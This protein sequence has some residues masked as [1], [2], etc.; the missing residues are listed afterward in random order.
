MKAKRRKRNKTNVT[1]EKDMTSTN[2]TTGGYKFA[3]HVASQLRRANQYEPRL[4]WAILSMVVLG[5]FGHT[6]ACRRPALAFS[7]AIHFAMKRSA[8]SCSAV[9]RLSP[10]SWAAVV[11]WSVSMPKALRSSRRRPI[12]SFSCPPHAARTP[13]QFAEHH[14]L[15]QSLIP[16]ARHKSREQDPPPT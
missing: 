4:L 14:A 10:P 3:P 8:A 13:H 1:P 16:H 15:R 2:Q 5:T 11:H 12:H 9:L 6:S 7:G